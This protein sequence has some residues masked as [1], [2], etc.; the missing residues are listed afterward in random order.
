[1]KDIL[2]IHHPLTVFWVNLEQCVLGGVLAV[3]KN[4]T[5]SNKEYRA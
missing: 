5:T 2:E 3:E 1:M 4:K